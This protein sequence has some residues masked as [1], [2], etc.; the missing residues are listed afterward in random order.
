MGSVKLV[1]DPLLT[2]ED[3]NTADWVLQLL[4]CQAEPEN[5]WESWGWGPGKAAMLSAVHHC[6]ISGEN[7]EVK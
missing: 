6:V 5:H 7:L 4:G 2:E 3:L 1:G